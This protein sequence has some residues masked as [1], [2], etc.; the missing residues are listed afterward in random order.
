MTSSAIR[1][2]SS[3][4]MPV[5][6]GELVADVREH[7]LAE[8]LRV[9]ADVEELRPEIADDGEVDAVLDLRERVVASPATRLRG[10]EALVQFHLSASSRSARA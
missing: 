2:R 3:R 9:D 6:C 8:R 4:E 5:S 7:A 10:V 1:C